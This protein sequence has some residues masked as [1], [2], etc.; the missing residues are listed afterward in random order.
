MTPKYSEKMLHFFY[1]EAGVGVYSSQTPLVFTGEAGSQAQEAILRLQLCIQENI[2]V[3]SKYQVYG[4]PFVIA[5]AA[6]LHQLVDGRP[7]A[8]CRA[9]GVKE[10]VKDL[11]LPSTK[12]YCAVHAIEA[13]RGAIR[14]YD[15]SS[16]DYDSSTT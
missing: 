5:T 15:R 2:V 14:E 3:S 10:L 1:N 11:D 9:I 4:D 8:D 7:L 13:L 6:Y 16:I 12:Q